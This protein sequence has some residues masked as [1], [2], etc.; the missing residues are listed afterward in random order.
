MPAFKRYKGGRRDESHPV[1]RN[2][3]LKLLLEDAR[4]SFDSEYTNNQQVRFLAHMYDLRLR[5]EN[6]LELFATRVN[7]R[8]FTQTNH[9]T[10]ILYWFAKFKWRSSHGDEYLQ[11]ALSILLAEPTITSYTACRNLWNLYAFNFYDKVA[12]ERFSQ[13]ILDTK[14]DQLNELDIANAVRSLAHFKHT[15]YDVLE[16]LLKQSIRRAD[17]FKL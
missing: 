17:T 13:V 6:V 9:L 14:P 5:D 16:V 4:A 2:P 1:L 11:T 12:L 8:Q 7:D 10:Q 15:D 3:A